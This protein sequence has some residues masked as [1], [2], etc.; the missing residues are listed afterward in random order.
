MK[1]T[2]EVPTQRKRKEEKFNTPVITMSALAKKGS[3]RR[4]TFNK[5][6]EDLLGVEPGESYASIGFGENGEIAVMVS[7]KETP[8]SYAIKKTNSS[9]SNKKL[10]EFIAK[11]KNLDTDVENYLHLNSETIEGLDNAYAI[12]Q[13][14]SENTSTIDSPSVEEDGK[15]EEI[16][17]EAVDVEENDESETPVEEVAEIDEQEW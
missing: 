5:A 8:N 14:T 7:D 17:L 12:S 3:G 13:F 9:F 10:Y 1:F 4:F 15:D 16:V 2:F 11:N 6:A